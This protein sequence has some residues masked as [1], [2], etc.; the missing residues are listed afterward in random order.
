ML[1]RNHLNYWHI[2]RFLCSFHGS[3]NQIIIILGGNISGLCHI[4]IQGI[5]HH[6][7]YIANFKTNLVFLHPT[8]N[9]H[10]QRLLQGVQQKEWV[11]SLAPFIYLVWCWCWSK[12]ICF[13]IGQEPCQLDDSIC[14]CFGSACFCICLTFSL[15][16][17]I[18]FRMYI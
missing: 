14:L 16:A 2:D 15:F 6:A 10:W 5:T 1:K 7:Q 18:A 3:Q 12:R 11:V 9:Q 4:W 13:N 8:N 17:S